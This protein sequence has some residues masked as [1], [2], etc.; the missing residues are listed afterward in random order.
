[1]LGKIMKLQK[2]ANCLPHHPIKKSYVVA[3]ME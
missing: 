1:M 2:D 3:V